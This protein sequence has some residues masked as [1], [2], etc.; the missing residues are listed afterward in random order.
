MAHTVCIS[1][2]QTSV[3]ADSGWCWT[4]EGPVLCRTKQQDAVCAHHGVDVLQGHKQA[5]QDVLDLAA[6]LVCVPCQ[7]QV[8]QVAPT[9]PLHKGV[10]KPA[11]DHMDRQDD[12]WDVVARKLPGKV[13]L[14]LHL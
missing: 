6:E 9:M 14:C 2:R 5:S 10:G 7:G 12:A 11:P 4:T 1:G 13:G 3:L 8:P